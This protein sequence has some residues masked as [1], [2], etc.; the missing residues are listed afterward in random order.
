VSLERGVAEQPSTLRRPQ[1]PLVELP[2]HLRATVDHAAMVLRGY[3]EPYVSRPREAGKWS[4]KQILGHLIDS[5]ANNHQRFVRVQFDQEFQ[6]PGYRQDA[7]VAAQDYQEGSWNDL[8]EL[9]VAYNRHL[10]R[11]VSLIPEVK[12]GKM[13]SVGGAP[14]VSLRFIAEDYLDHLRHHLRQLGVDFQ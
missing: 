7:W 11:V 9:W 6:D 1:G 12:L 14:P 5:A 3:G 2:E 8:L 10:A 13:V 4:P